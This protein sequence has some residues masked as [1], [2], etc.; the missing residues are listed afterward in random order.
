MN[1]PWFRALAFANALGCGLMAGVFFAFSTFVMRA[2]ASLP[3]PKGIAA[4]QAVNVVAVRSPFIVAFMGTAG[5]SLLL[6][7]L[8]GVRRGEVGA[9][10][11]LGGCLLFLIGTFLV[12]VVFNV[13]MNDALA[14]VSPDS[15]EGATLWADYLQRWTFWNHVRTVTSL[16][17]LGMMVWALVRSVNP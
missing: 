6:A 7:I 1:L 14:A 10:P 4:M 2:L 8:A 17:A 12:T 13:P 11:L 16:G 9:T 3:A 5:L 15:K